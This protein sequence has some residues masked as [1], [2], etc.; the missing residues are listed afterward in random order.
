MSALSMKVFSALYGGYDKV[1]ELPVGLPLPAIMYT[2][3]PNLLAPGWEV[4]V[5]NHGIVTLNGDPEVTGPMLAHKFWKM[6][7]GRDE[8]DVTVWLDASMTIAVDDFDLRC[9]GAIEGVDIALMNH[10]WRG[11]IYD[12]VDYSASLPRYAS[13]KTQLIE[14]ADF[15]REIGHPEG[16]GLYASGFYIRRNNPE[17]NKFM[18]SW[19]WENITRTHQDQV[20]LPVMVRLHEDVTTQVRLPWH[21]DP[22]CWTHLGFHLK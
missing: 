3:N 7:A 11:C 6:F 20:S 14:Q 16:W 10:P 17:V 5:V 19:W 13:M 12:E 1:P 8:C 22:G 15:Y 2:D 21:D 9:Q 4:R 18:D